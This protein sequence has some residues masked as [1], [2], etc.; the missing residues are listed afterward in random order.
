[1]FTF[2]AYFFRFVVFIYFSTVLIT[3][4]VFAFDLD[5]L[6]ELQQKALKKQLHNDPYW[7]KL[8]HYEV[9]LLGSGYTSLVDSPE[10]F[11]ASDGKVDPK[12]EI[13]ATLE[14]FFAR[15][16]VKRENIQ[17]PRQCAF[18]ARFHWLGQQ[19]QFDTR[20]LPALPCTDYEEWISTIAP[21]SV[22]LIFPSAYLNNPSSMFG[23][24]LLRIDREGQN[25]TS[26]LLSYSINYAART[27]ESSGMVFAYR[28]LIGQYPGF[29]S[30][31]PYYEKVNEYNDLENRDIWE[32][33]LNL[34]QIEILRMLRHTWELAGIYFEYYFIDENC[35]YQ[36]LGLLQLSRPDFQ[37]TQDFPVW[38]TPVDTLRTVLDDQDLLASVEYRPS[39]QTRIEHQSGFL[40]ASETGLVL[41]LVYGR[42]QPDDIVISSYPSQR[43]ALMSEIAFDYLQYLH[44]E[45]EMER[46]QV[47][48]RSIDLL[49]MRS[50]IDA[51]SPASKVPEPEYRPDQGH[52]TSRL[53]LRRGRL[54]HANY[55]ELSLRPTYH[56]LLDNRAGFVEGS[57]LNFFNIDLRYSDDSRDLKLQR[58]DFFDA[59]SLSRRSAFFNPLSWKLKSSYE[60]L[61]SPEVISGQL[62]F[63]LEGGIGPAWQF[64]SDVTLFALLD[65]SVWIDSKIPDNFAVGIGGNLGL[66]WPITDW[67][68]IWLSVRTIH[69]NNNLHVTIADHELSSNFSLSHSTALRLSLRQQGEVGESLD[70]V[71]IGFNWYF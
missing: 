51:M 47:A 6:K 19:L 44:N 54:E 14:G 31:L 26:Q 42:R 62:V 35:S 63:T 33:T 43:Q 36:L 41:D 16:T 9:N 1:M 56:D 7:H 66:H 65:S 11:N 57:Q 71:S 30:V 27:D 15:G 46:D 2:L 4:P 25:E 28:G 8:L 53:A 23:H 64:G 59:F 52:E 37:F 32:Y 40:T 13:L 17:Q 58:V 60:R 20:R 29:F 49:K 48:Q 18:I 39:A 3:G 68:T 67:W 21:R 5:Y 38:A 70:E 50:R 69:F 10:F 22:T 12:A 24:T 61:Y 45:Q 34:S 55:T